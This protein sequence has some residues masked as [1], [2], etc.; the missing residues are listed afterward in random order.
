[1]TIPKLAAIIVAIM[2]LNKF[3]IVDGAKWPISRHISAADKATSTSDLCLII[4]TS[5][6]TNMAGNVKLSPRRSG[7]VM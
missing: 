1:M 6:Q 7:L 3:P 4:K 2:I 5:K